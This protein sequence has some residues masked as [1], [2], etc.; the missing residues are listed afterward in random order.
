MRFLGGTICISWQRV[1]LKRVK[2]DGP[3]VQ[4]DVTSVTEDARWVTD[5]ITNVQHDATIFIV[6][7]AIVAI[8]Y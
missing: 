2:H 6:H 4:G 7:F 3:R 8:V 1:W 5:D